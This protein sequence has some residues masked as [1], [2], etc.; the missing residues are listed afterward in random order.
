MSQC[1][2]LT[3]VVHR[4]DI[5]MSPRSRQGSEMH[6]IS[7]PHFYLSAFIAALKLIPLMTRGAIS[8]NNSSCVVWGSPI[9]LQCQFF[10]SFFAEHRSWGCTRT[11]SLSLCLHYYCSATETDSSPSFRPPGRAYVMSTRDFH[12][13]GRWICRSGTPDPPSGSPPHTHVSRP[14][15]IG[16]LKLTLH[17]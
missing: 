3:P 10:S 8:R 14:L 9:R 6:C 16:I 11:G 2:R 5:S 12:P 1:T 13:P 15:Y 17:K 7:L 4:Y